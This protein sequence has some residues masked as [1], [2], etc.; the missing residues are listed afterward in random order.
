MKPI[1]TGARRQA[2]L[3]ARLL[4]AQ[5]IDAVMMFTERESEGAVYVPDDVGAEDQT[6]L[7][8]LMLGETGGRCESEVLWLRWEDIDLEG[9]RIN[10]VSGR[11]GHRTKGGKS[12]RVPVTPRLREALRDHFAAY[13]FSGSS[14]VFHHVRRNAHAERGDRIRGLRRAVEGAA[15]R[16]ELPAGFRQHDLR[17]RRVTKW[18]AEGASVVHVQHAVGH[19]NIA[20]TMKYTHLAD[21]HV[22]ALLEHEARG[23]SVA[24]TAAKA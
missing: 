19:A 14:W 7:Y 13:R 1:F 11:D 4:R 12:R 10:I 22:D 18:L 6:R 21:E 15:K 23:K 24:R 17:H 8:V 9:S 2:A 5:H 3:L 16:A 20:T